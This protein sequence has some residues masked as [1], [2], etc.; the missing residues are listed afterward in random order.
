MAEARLERLEQELTQMEEG[1][2]KPQEISAN[3][4][5]AERE[6]RDRK[7]RSVYE[8]ELIHEALDTFRTMKVKDLIESEQLWREIKDR[9]GEYYTGGMGAEA[10]KDLLGN[11]DVD[12]E[13]E[14][15]PRTSPPTRRSAASGPPSASRWCPRS[16]QGRNAPER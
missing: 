3:R 1:G 16:P 9:Y 13:M 2:A 10:I 8:E 15:L 12:A 14:Q 7:E 11:F 5:E 6:I 4:R